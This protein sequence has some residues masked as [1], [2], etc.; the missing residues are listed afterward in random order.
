M[1][2]TIR[3]TL[4]GVLVAG[5]LTA[6]HACENPVCGCE[7]AREPVGRWVGGTPWR[8]SV[9]LVL[10]RDGPTQLSGAGAL[11]P[12]PLRSSS[13]RTISVHGSMD[14]ASRTPTRLTVIG[15]YEQPSEWRSA[16]AAGA[17]TQNGHLYPPRGQES[18]DTLQ[19]WLRR[20]PE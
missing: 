3:N 2:R 13:R 17:A 20:V 15:W 16:S 14:S 4:A 9:D 18:G 12:G 6:L 5:A 19:L 8:D 11:I 7:P 1:P 10:Y